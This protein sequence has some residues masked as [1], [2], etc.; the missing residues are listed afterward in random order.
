MRVWWVVG[1]LCV[2]VA[3][4][5]D[6]GSHG[7]GGI[8]GAAGGV[9]GGG[10][11][12]GAVAP[13]TRAEL[14]FLGVT[15]WLL[16]YGE[17][18]VLLD[19][20]FSRPQDRVGGSTDEGLDLL[21]RVLDAAGVES[22]DFILVGHSHFDH[23]IDSGAAAMMTG[24]QVVGS[25]TTCFVAQSA[26]LP[27]D[28][29]TVVGT[30]DELQLGEAR[31]RAVRT[32]HTLPE[33]L[34]RFLEFD[35]VPT[36]EDSWAAPAGGAISYLVSFPGDEPFSMF[37]TNS[38]SSIDGDDGSGEDYRANL[39]TAFSDVDGATAWL[40]PVGFL[41]A[42]ADLIDYFSPIEPSFVVPHHFDG[43]TPDI[44]AGLAE[45]F[46]PSP[47]LTQALADE[48]AT[49]V[50]PEQY[51]E[52]LILTPEGLTRSEDPLAPAAFGF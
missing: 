50:A 11:A 12:G 7:G 33:S 39:D 25:Q 48:G 46:M 47:A 21:Q 29:C 24:A 44:E 10:G 32:I 20:Y 5:S 2:L 14:T 17:T 19:A 22:V 3:S 16:Q 42:E 35:E 51:F 52:V 41:G 28:R 8:G 4:C 6:S 31:M 1:V 13:V 15:Q 40:G 36:P 27:E 45:P 38:I 9:G 30:G 34:G 26:G 49:L 23:A 43:L 37:Y 18:T